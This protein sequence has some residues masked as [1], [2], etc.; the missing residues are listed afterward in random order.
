[1]ESRMALEIF[2]WNGCVIYGD[3]ENW[4][5]GSSGRVEKKGS[6]S[7]VLNLRYLFFF[8]FC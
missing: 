7:D 4:E 8:P 5:D 2:A 1:M 3:R 6:G